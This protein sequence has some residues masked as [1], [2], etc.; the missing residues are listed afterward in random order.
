MHGLI[1]WVRQV[2]A[3]PLAVPL[4]AKMVAL[5]TYVEEQDPLPGPRTKPEWPGLGSTKW[6]CCLSGPLHR[7]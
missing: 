5:S 7:I 3:P 4:L 1:R 6:Q 2:D